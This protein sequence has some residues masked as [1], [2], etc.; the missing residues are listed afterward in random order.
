MAQRIN[1]FD[2]RAVWSNAYKSEDEFDEWL[3][4]EIAEE[5][6]DIARNLASLPDVPKWV[7]A[8]LE[9]RADIIE[10]TR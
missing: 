8:A 2:V 4:Y 5:V 3:A 1:R 7:A 6:R 9:F 10:V